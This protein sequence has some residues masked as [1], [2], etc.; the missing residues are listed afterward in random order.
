MD[1]RLPNSPIPNNLRQNMDKLK[2]PYSVEGY[3]GS[4]APDENRQEDRTYHS[5]RDDDDVKTINIGLMDNDMVIPYYFENIIKPTVVKDGNTINVPVIYGSSEVW[6]TVQRDGYYRD[7]ESKIQVPL[8][9]FKR[10]SVTK[11]R[12]IGN[13]LDGNQAHLFQVFEKKYTKRN[14]YDNF[15]VITNRIP[16]KEFHAVVV[17][18]YVTLS[19][20]CVIWTDY[21]E[22]MNKL[23]EAINFASDSYWGDKNTFKFR[24]RIDSFQNQ[25]EVNVGDNRLIRTTFTL[26]LDGYLIPDSYNRFLANKTKFSSK[27]QIKITDEQFTLNFQDESGNGQLTSFTTKGPGSIT[28]GAISN[29]FPYFGDATIT[30]SLY[31]SSNLN[32]GGSLS[33]SNIDGPVT[34]TDSSITGSFTGSFAGN[35]SQLTNIPSDAIVGLELNKIASGSAT[36]SISPNNGL[37]INTDTTIDGDLIVRGTG[38][39]DVIH[40]T[41]ETSSILYSSGSTKFGNTLDDTHEITGSFSV[42]GSTVDFSNVDTI[43]GINTDNFANADLTLDANRTHDLNGFNALLEDGYVGINT[44]GST[45]ANTRLQVYINDDT[46]RGI[47][48][49]NLTSNSQ[50]NMWTRQ[51]YGTNAF[52]LDSDSTGQTV[53]IA[54]ENLNVG[55]GLGTGALPQARLHAKGPGATPATTSLLVENSSA[56]QILKID[57]AGGFVVGI[58]AT[59]GNEDCIAI[60]TNAD[61]TDNS[62]PTTNTGLIAIGP[63]AVA[64][65]SGGIAI[66]RDAFSNST[67]TALGFSTFAQF[68]STAVGYNANAANT[69]V[70]LGRDADASN[71]R[72]IALGPYSE[73]SRFGSIAIGYLAEAKTAGNYQIALGASSQV[74]ADNS[75]LISTKG[76]TQTNSTA[77]TFEVNLDNTTSVFRFGNTVDGWLNSTGNFGFGTTTPQAKLH[78]SGALQIDENNGSFQM[79]TNQTILNSGSNVIYDSIL[80]SSYDGAFFEYMVKSGSNARAG[81]IMSVWEGN[82]LNFTETTTTDIGS[83]SDVNFT[84]FITGSNIALTGS[85]L[86][87]GWIMNTIIKTL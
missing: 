33:V 5:R 35:G 56:S 49:K 78:V 13:K 44:S 20:D 76:S 14:Q 3:E 62:S 27:T 31:V 48:I 81:S 53:L 38:S 59:I 74:T 7:K 24:A 37:E 71:T 22:N 46:E 43:L 36:A 51:L 54:D 58:G 25:T 10:T 16:E 12:D 86:T 61:A 77:N 19:Y 75:V 70:A 66:G 39:F 60:G 69:G 6:K 50:F 18:D 28:G 1:R 30:G 57:D 32:I 21:V 42:T 45:T 73:A 8:I 84:L 2:V 52:I 82:Q 55:I 85:A 34:I 40:T 65:G 17:P 9:M 41:Y 47:R 63:N 80:T 67:S 72:A 79:T 64:N 87:D 29:I 11:R 83:T 68:N 26:N 23:I 4:K 15:S